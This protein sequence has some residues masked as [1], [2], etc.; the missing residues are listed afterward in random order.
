MIDVDKAKAL[1]Q[2]N[3]PQVA[4]Q[5]VHPITRDW[6]SFVLELNDEMIFRFPMRD[7]VIAYLQKE[8]GLLPV[9]EQTLSTPIPHFDYIGHGDASYP[10]NLIW[11]PLSQV[12]DIAQCV[13]ESLAVLPGLFEVPPEYLATAAW[14]SEAAVLVLWPSE[15]G[16]HDLLL[17][18]VG[19]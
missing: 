11:H 3:F 7:D 8:I 12:I 4:I 6:D 5:T 2:R 10:I 1:I 9:L 15:A 17:P 19:L 16:P 13:P 14:R 18:A